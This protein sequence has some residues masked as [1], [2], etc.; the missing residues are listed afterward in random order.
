MAKQ[1]RSI[2]VED[3]TPATER[4]KRLLSEFPE[5]EVIAEATNGIEA[6]EIID[7][8]N[9]DLLFLDIKMP[10]KNGFEVLKS[11]QP[12]PYVIFCSAYDEYALQA[13]EE[14]SIDYLVKPVRKEKL[15]K[16]IQK[17]N[18]FSSTDHYNHL[19]DSVQEL[20]SL[21]QPAEVT[22]LPIKKSDRVIFLKLADITH[23]NASE[24]YVEVH[25]LKGV[26]HL[27]DQSLRLL[28]EKL[29]LNFIRIHRSY[30][31]NTDKIKEIRK[32]FGGKYSFI[33]DDTRSTAILSGRSYYQTVKSL[34]DL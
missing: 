4:L 29:P 25:T 8:L 34:F 18:T 11:I 7:A 24:K 10:G 17:L 31:I 15:E 5:I 20:L 22:T 19:L 2:I 13:F 33:L 3:E 9:P 14:K 16:S 32:H 26:T 30:I 28:E 1:F 27:T 12:S 6:V 21:K 23:F